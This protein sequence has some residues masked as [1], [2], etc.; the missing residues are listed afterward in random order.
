M[1]ASSL[2]KIFCLKST[3]GQDLRFFLLCFLFL[4]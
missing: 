1:F 4:L 2:L 3:L